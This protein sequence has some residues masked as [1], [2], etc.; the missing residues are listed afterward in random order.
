MAERRRMSIPSLFLRVVLR[1]YCRTNRSGHDVLYTVVACWSAVQQVTVHREQVQLPPKIKK[2]PHTF[3]NCSFR[4]W[5]PHIA[6]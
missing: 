5:Q 2:V 4:Q 1:Q 3:R 6:R